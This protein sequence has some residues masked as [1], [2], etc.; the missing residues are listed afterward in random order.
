MNTRSND[1]LM[2]PSDKNL[3]LDEGNQFGSVSKHV[4][5]CV[6]DGLLFK[7]FGN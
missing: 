2:I 3:E 6:D 1:K 7:A 4:G 5:K